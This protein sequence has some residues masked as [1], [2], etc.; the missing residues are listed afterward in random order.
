M[1]LQRMDNVLIVVDDLKA[2]KGASSHFSGQVSS[3]AR[4]EV[5]I[6]FHRFHRPALSYDRNRSMASALARHQKRLDPFK[7]R[8]ITRRTA[9]SS[10]P[11]PIGSF[12]ARSLAY[13]I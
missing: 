1:T 7:R 4:G 12:M 2:A 6:R 13:A 3:R 8:F 11:L 10:A 5:A 9:L